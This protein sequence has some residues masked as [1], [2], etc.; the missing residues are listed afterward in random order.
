VCH[1]RVLLPRRRCCR[2]VVPALLSSSMHGQARPQADSAGWRDQ[3]GRPSPSRPGRAT[4]SG[5]MTA[6]ITWL[7]RGQPLLP[8]LPDPP[9][10]GRG[11]RPA[12]RRDGATRPA[13]DPRQIRIPEH[14]AGNVRNFPAAA[15]PCEPVAAGPCPAVHAVIRVDLQHPLALVDAVHR[16][17][18]YARP[19]QHIHARLADH[20]D[21]RAPSRLCALSSF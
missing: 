16:A 1:R 17:L 14:E 12:V 6:G 2:P 4:W 3:P 9:P 5:S 7:G 8:P 21:H 13:H 18:L 19:V 10:P 20:V 15:P 11:Q